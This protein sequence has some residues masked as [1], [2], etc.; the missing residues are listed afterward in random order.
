MSDAEQDI[1]RCTKC[2][3]YHVAGEYHYCQTGLTP[4]NGTRVRSR[5]NPSNKDRDVDDGWSGGYASAQKRY[6][7]SRAE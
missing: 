2:L 5:G 6:E 1:V 7:D 4:R 3:R